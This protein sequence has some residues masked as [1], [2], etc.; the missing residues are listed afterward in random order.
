[1]PPVA[2]FFANAIFSYLK[3]GLSQLHVMAGPPIQSLIT[4]KLDLFTGLLLIV[5]LY[6]SL[7]ILI[8]TTKMIFRMVVNLF[9]LI[10]FLAFLGTVAWCYIR[11]FDGVQQ[12]LS[13]LMATGQYADLYDGGDFTQKVHEAA[14]SQF[15]NLLFPAAD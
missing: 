1:M 9:K 13:Y 3:L 5:V 11:G 8:S 4:T 6:V 14:Q 7:L 15:K 2:S 12:D 10:F